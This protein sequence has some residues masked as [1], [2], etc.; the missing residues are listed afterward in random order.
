MTLT[1]ASH[2]RPPRSGRPDH[3]D[4]SVWL[5]PAALVLLT[6]IPLVAG[7]LRLVEV[8]GGP[9]LLPSNPRIADSPFPLM[10]H[11]GSSVV[12]AVLG[13]FQFPARMRRAH[14]TW[15]RRSGRL[16]AGAGLVVAGSAL[17]MT[18][19]YTGAPGGLLLWVVRLMVA[20]TLAVSLLLGISAIRRGDVRA[21]RAWMIR[22]YA[23]AVAAGTQAFTQGVG[24]GLFG[25]GELST[26]LSVSAGWAINAAA[27]EFIIRRSRVR[28]ARR[29]PTVVR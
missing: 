1:T 26:A 2:A 24:E 7:T 13:A 16:L 8:A 20:C 10:L 28:R 18:L 19:A 25:T 4:N 27:A 14:P 3:R 9:H 5:V 12:Y 17:W 29:T 15:H 6:A 21:H 22:A 11:V 23:L